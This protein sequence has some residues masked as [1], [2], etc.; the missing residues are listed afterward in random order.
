MIAKRSQPLFVK[1]WAQTGRLNAHIEET[2]TPGTRSSRS[3]AGRRGGGDLRASA[4][5]RCSRR[6]S[7]RSSSPASSMPAIMFIGNLNYVSDRGASV[8]CGSRREPVARRRAGVHPVLAPVHPAAHP[9]RRR[10]P[11]CCSPASRRPSASSSCSTPTSSCPTRQSRRGHEPHGRVAFEHVS[12]RY[13]PDMPLIDDLSL[14]GRPRPVGRDRRADRAPAR[15]RWST[16]SCGSTSSTAAA[17]RSTASTSR[18]CD[19][20][21]CAARS[22]WSS[23]TPGCSTARSATTS[24]TADRTRREEEI[25]EAARGDVRRPVRARAARRLRHGD[26]RRGQQHQRGRAA[27]ASPSP[28]RSWP[29]R[30][31]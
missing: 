24:R 22:A 1:Q 15:R 26:R 23:R 10:W 14:G 12:F 25:L 3:S 16:W 17:S 6:A 19:A 13:V 11:T 21:T 4:T 28:G 2:S 9:G 8:V 29:T 18:R 27:A 30:R 5:R 20:T 7:A 31:C